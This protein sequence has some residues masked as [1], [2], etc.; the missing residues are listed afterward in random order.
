LPDRRR[1]TE[2]DL[3]ERYLAG[4]R[5]HGVSVDDDWLWTEYRRSSYAG[6]LMAVVASILVGQTD[7]G[8]EMFLAMA[9]RSARLAADVDAADLLPS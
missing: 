2:R 3:I 1:D 9:D 7:R 5:A 6:L 8:D 4:V